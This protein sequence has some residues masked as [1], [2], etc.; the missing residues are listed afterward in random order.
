M[1][2]SFDAVIS[3]EDHVNFETHQ[4]ERTMSRIRIC[5]TAIVFTAIIS[6]GAAIAQSPPSPAAAKAT[7]AT[8]GADSSKPSKAT[9]VETWTTK[10][11]DGAKK[12]WAKDKAK[13]AS[14]EKQSDKQKLEGRKSWSFLYTCMTS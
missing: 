4:G 12:E 6:S 1:D 8:A 3:T 14:C 9:Q 5:L 2:L 13:W 11:W 10:Q 7:P